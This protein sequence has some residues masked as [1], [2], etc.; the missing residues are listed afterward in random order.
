VRTVTHVD[1]QLLQQSKVKF[2]GSMTAGADHLDTAWL[3][4]AGIGWCVAA[5]FNA[6]VANM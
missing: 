1:K 2:V 5:G 4:N 6:P 3:D